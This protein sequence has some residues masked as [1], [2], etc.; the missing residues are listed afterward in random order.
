VAQARGDLEP[1]DG[2]HG[3]VELQKASA[4]Y[5]DVVSKGEIAQT[6]QADK[7]GQESI[8]AYGKKEG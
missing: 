2:V 3:W 8:I 7:T 4:F 1:V 6:G 5:G